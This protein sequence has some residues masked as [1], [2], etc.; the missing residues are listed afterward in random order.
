MLLFIYL[1]MILLFD[2]LQCILIDSGLKGIVLKFINILISIL[3]D[4]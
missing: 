2:F 1:L 4:F 3:F